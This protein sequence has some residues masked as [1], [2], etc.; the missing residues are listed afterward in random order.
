MGN[1]LIIKNNFKVRIMAKTEIDL[2]IYS[3][4]WGHKDTYKI[5]LTSKS[6]TITQN[7]RVAVCTWREDLDP[8]WSG[9]ILE[10]I[11]RNDHIYPPT[12]YQDL[13]EHA[14]KAWRNGEL[15]DTG[16]NNELQELASWL[17]KVTS[18][19]PNTIFWQQYF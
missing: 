6:L 9:E 13:I 1:K 2:D 12:I 5:E 4:R 15:D 16:V 19:K 14:W 10:R 17:N 7:A 3:P 18:A 8:E 11:L